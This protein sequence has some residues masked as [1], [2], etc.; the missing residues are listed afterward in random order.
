MAGKILKAEILP[1]KELFTGC[2]N[3]YALECKLCG[4][5]VD[6]L[7]DTWKWRKNHK[8]FIGQRRK[9]NG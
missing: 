1:I 6:I 5:S 4:E 8:C 2:G 9:G 3:V 7:S